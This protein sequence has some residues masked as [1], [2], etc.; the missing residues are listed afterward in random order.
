MGIIKYLSLKCKK[1]K[2][3]SLIELSV[4]ISVAAAATV[5]FLGWT[6]PKNITDARKTIET[7]QMIREVTKAIKTFKVQRGR[8]PCPSDPFMR[9]DN[10]RNVAGGTDNYANDFGKEDL[11]IVQTQVNGTT[12]L[13]VDCHD[14]IGAL[15]VYDLSLDQKYMLDAWGRKITYAVSS[16]LCGADAGTENVTSQNSNDIGCDKQNYE[17]G[18]G[19]LTVNRDSVAITK[20]AAFVLVSHGSNGSGAFLPSGEKLSASGNTA[21]DLNSN[22]A[23]SVF[24][25]DRQ[26]ATFD[27]VVEF[28]TKTQIEKL[29]D[30]SNIKQISV[31]ECEEN[32]Q[33]LKG[34]TLANAAAFKSNLGDHA[35]G[36]RN[37]GEE[38]ALS[39]LM[40]IQTI[41]V[42][43]YGVPAVGVGTS[44]DGESWNG[45]QCP[46]Y[47]T[48]A[49]G[50]A[51]TYNAEFN[52]C[53]CKGAVWGGSCEMDWNAIMPV[54][55]GQVLWL[56]AMDSDTLFSNINCRDGQAPA[57]GVDV[58][59]WKDKS[60]SGVHATTGAYFDLANTSKF[61]ARP[62][63][64]NSANFNS[65]PTLTFLKTDNDQ[66]I[67]RDAP[68]LVADNGPR[69]L[70]IVMRR[71]TTEAQI[72]VLGADSSHR[73]GWGEPVW[74]GF[75]G[76]ILGVTT[77]GSL[78]FNASHIVT[79]GGDGAST[80]VFINGERRT[81][82][83]SSLPYFSWAINNNFAIGGA[84]EDQHLTAYMS[85]LMIYNK[86]L[87]N[88]ERKK[89]ERYLSDKW[90]VTVT[91]N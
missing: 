59:C 86:I 91:H 34:V 23:S 89:V 42:K 15:P 71:Y 53:T 65:R 49:N 6:Q 54:R 72:T 30:H 16:D 38:V 82:V 79:V 52:V 1:Q 24:R 3:F 69:T 17:K 41:C 14:T 55:Q 63:T 73:F 46:G 77:N 12:T 67:L 25:K 21:E 80:S 11:D 40:N 29:V 50:T 48:V 13:G 81:E 27:D 4:I 74:G 68:E 76:G 18:F 37:T 51:P 33:A 85:E 84:N 28:A 83:T 32:S 19:N 43:Y 7:K 70:F 31:A 90:G 44:I 75:D 62:P 8:L 2:G 88:T 66:L 56:D 87:N 9:A 64:Y 78:P 5:G 58:N 57:N 39:L 60:P 61:T 35:Q 47:N 20:K 10:A 45:P 22:Y 26:S 36:D